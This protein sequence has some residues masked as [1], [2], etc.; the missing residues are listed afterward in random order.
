MLVQYYWTANHGNNDQS[1]VGDSGLSENR[2]RLGE[3]FLQSYNVSK[4]LGSSHSSNILPCAPCS[5]RMPVLLPVNPF[6]W[7]DCMFHGSPDLKVS[8]AGRLARASGCSTE[9]SPLTLYH[10]QVFKFWCG[11]TLPTIILLYTF[12][13][14]IHIMSRGFCTPRPSRWP[15]SRA[16]GCKIPVLGI[17]LDPWRM[18]FPLNPDSR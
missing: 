12:K 17:S 7:L 15:M 10:S 5:A 3:C 4:L 16:S 1:S 6:K 18:H 14:C 11:A 9:L 2:I 13:Y 8:T